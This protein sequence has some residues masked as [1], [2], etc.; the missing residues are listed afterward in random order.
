[1]LR[2]CSVFLETS[3]VPSGTL[4]GSVTV[5]EVIVKVSITVYSNSGDFI[6]V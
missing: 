4:T 3:I 2:P 6:L 5:D 1:M